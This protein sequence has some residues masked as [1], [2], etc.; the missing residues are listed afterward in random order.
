MPDL[1]TRYLGLPLRTPLVASSSPLTGTLDG[2]RRLEDAGAAAVVLPSLFEEDLTRDALAVHGALEAGTGTF[3]EALDYMPDLASYDVG[4]D[5]Y[6][7]LLAA[8]KR[9]LGIPVLA[10]LNGTTPGGWIE[11]ARRIEEAGADAL[12][13]NLYQVAADPAHSSVDL[14]RRDLELVRALRKELRIPLAVKLSPYFT[15]LANFACCL[16]DAGADGLVLFNRFYQPD[17]DLETL[18]VAPHL[19]LSSSQELR[20]PLRWIA[21]LRGRVEASLAATSGV[22]TPEDVLKVLLAG[23]DAAML[24]SALL[25]RGPALLG[26]LERAIARWMDEREYESVEQLKGSMSQGASPDPEAFERSNYRRTLR[27]FSSSFR[28]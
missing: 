25:E 14:E 16:A 18:E 23:A 22:H 20:L 24:A 17:F 26:E 11:H 5:G 9:A 19:V 7:E 6:L 3:A 12:E 2:L 21:I 27:S 4:P 13:L 28:S 15:A 8:A 10:S 1:G